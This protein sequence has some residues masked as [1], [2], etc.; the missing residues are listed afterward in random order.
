[1]RRTTPADAVTPG[2]SLRCPEARS[3]QS[4]QPPQHSTDS[5]CDQQA[6]DEQAA[7]VN[8]L[9]TSVLLA[10]GK[11]EGAGAGAQMAGPATGLTLDLGV[12]EAAIAFRQALTA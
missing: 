1:V 5:G 8:K 12:A 2:I 4:P 6:D 3:P 11:R 9:T 7:K 10:V